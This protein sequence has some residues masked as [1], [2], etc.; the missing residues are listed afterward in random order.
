MEGHGRSLE[1]I[2]QLVCIGA[3]D[4]TGANREVVRLHASVVH[5]TKGA[6]RQGILPSGPE[7]RR[8][9]IFRD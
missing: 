6:P 3:S 5:M 4:V 7:D 1:V 9:S 2:K 8:P